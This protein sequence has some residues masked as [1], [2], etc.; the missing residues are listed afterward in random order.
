LL[1]G[2]VHDLIDAVAVLDQ[3]QS[4]SGE[5]SLPRP[6]PLLVDA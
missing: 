6:L 3:A 1:K 2:L 5:K 4:L